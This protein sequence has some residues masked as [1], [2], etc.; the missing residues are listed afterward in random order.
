MPLETIPT[1]PVF[2][3]PL[4][5]ASDA[6]GV[7][8]AN[9]LRFFYELPGVLTGINAAGAG[10]NQIAVAAQQAAALIGFKGE[11]ATQTGALAWPASVEHDGELWA[12]LVDLADVTANEPSEASTVWSLVRE[13]A[14]RVAYGASHVAAA[15]DALIARSQPS[16]IVN[17]NFSV[18]QALKS[19]TVT[20]G[21]GA[22]AHSAWKAG[23]SGCTYTF[24]T[25]GGVTTLTI[26]AGSL[27]Q[28]VDG[29]EVSTGVHTLSWVGTANARISGGSYASSGMTA[30]LTRGTNATVEFATGTVSLVRL[31]PGLIATPFQHR[32]ADEIARCEYRLPSQ[33]SAAAA[34][35]GQGV[36]TGTGTGTIGV[37]LKATPRAIPTGFSLVGGVLSDLEVT[38]GVSSA[39]VTGL[40]FLSAS[41]GRVNLLVTWTGGPSSLGAG[42]FLNTNSVETAFLFTGAEPA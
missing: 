30:T 7:Y 28:V 33:R 41:D 5:S 34:T 16:L 24:A 37:T 27:L 9:A 22:R 20:L 36:I 2:S 25:S 11:W 42:I 3:G 31:E 13:S 23:A 32:P 21:A 4:P 40:A 19:G 10:I 18:N 29:L 15:L 8:E 26:T 1:V 35:I 38:T 14:E 12:L 6:D 17:G 39:T